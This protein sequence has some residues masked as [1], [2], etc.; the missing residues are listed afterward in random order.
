MLAKYSTSHL[1]YR[2][3]IDYDF[4]IEISNEKESK[5]RP[6][7]KPLCFPQYNERVEVNYSI[8]TKSTTVKA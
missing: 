2:S 7:I 5:I 1:T 8:A 3:N 6:T 4:V